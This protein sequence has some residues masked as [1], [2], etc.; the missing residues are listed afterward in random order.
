MAY[1]KV[2]NGAELAFKNSCN[3]S[4][5]TGTKTPPKGDGGKVAVQLFVTIMG[6]KYELEYHSKN[7][8]FALGSEVNA[9]NP[10][11]TG[12]DCELTWYV[13]TSPFATL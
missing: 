12:N 13:I 3:A 5:G 11:L 1:Q 7:C 10:N 2:D 8:T 6:V 9:F 4:G